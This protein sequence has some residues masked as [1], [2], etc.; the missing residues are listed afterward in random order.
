MH[1]FPKRFS[2][3]D[4]RRE[5]LRPG[6]LGYIQI[7]EAVDVCGGAKKLEIAVGTVDFRVIQNRLQPFQALRKKRVVVVENEDQRMTRRRDASVAR[8][9][10]PAAL[11]VIDPPETS[12]AP[13]RAHAV[14]VGFIGAIIDHD[15]LP[16]L[17]RLGGDTGQALVEKRPAIERGDDDRNAHTAASAAVLIGVIS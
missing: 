15:R 14:G 2:H 7:L 3:E 13:F 12:V 10:R 1:P 11:R 8:R 17:V 5:K 4:L 6:Q 16:V 9:G